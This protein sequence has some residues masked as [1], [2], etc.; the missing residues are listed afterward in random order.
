MHSE[1]QDSARAATAISAAWM[2]GVLFVLWAAVVSA[3]PVSSQVDRLLSDS[4][5][6]ESLSWDRVVVEEQ[7]VPR[8]FTWRVAGFRDQHPALRLSFPALPPFGREP[9]SDVFRPPARAAV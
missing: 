7:P 2:L 5:P 1:G 6:A 8:T 4:Q 3:S 9:T